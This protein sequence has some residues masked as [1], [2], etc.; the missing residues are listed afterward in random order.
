[1][2]QQFLSLSSTVCFLLVCGI[3]LWL[4]ILSSDTNWNIK[5]NP[6]DPESL[7]PDLSQALDDC[8][9]YADYVELHRSTVKKLQQGSTDVKLLVYECHDSTGL[10]GGLG[11]RISGMA[12][13]FYASVA[14]GRA[15]VIDQSKPLLLQHVLLPRSDINWNVAHLIPTE[16]G[17][18]SLKLIDTFTVKGISKL[19]QPGLAKYTVL[20]VAMNRYYSGRA[21][22]WQ[23][24]N[25]SLPWFFGSMYRL[26]SVKCSKQADGSDTYALAFN[27]LFRPSPLVE[28]R[29]E[30]MR[31]VLALRHTDGA[32]KSFLAIHARV[33][34]V[35]NDD[36][37]TAGWN[38]PAR[39]TFAKTSDA[40]A[41]VRCAKGKLSTIIM[42][43][44]DH[45]G[46]PPIILFSD[47]KT[48]KEEC[49]KGHPDLRYLNDSLT[50]HVDKSSGSHEVVLKGFVDAVAEFLLLS[51]ASCIVG[52]SSTFSGSAAS[53][54]KARKGEPCYFYF[55]E[56]EFL[57]SDFWAQTEPEFD[58]KGLKG[59]ATY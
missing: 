13:L 25:P 1:M 48:F 14:L 37:G 18:T 24:N 17:T 36:E 22:W 56:C 26:H 16:L 55:R 50:F 3:A 42:Q 19:F 29:I 33:G 9:W 35:V 43:E 59:L 6:H 41:L 45:D 49:S 23:E 58:A 15:F 5:R 21:L 20:R 46:L 38:D 39:P 10:C 31:S 40:D 51:S 47:S 4:T 28:K 12:S 2:R 8:P 57:I 52:S 34:G 30:R 7:P 32:S 53:L 11:D 44:H 54:M 27:I